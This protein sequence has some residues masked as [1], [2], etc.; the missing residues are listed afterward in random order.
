MISKEPPIDVRKGTRLKL[1]CEDM[2]PTNEIITS[3]SPSYRINSKLNP[4]MKR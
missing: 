4:R 1:F 2:N 3:T